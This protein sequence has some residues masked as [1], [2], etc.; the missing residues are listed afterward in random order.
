MDGTAGA[1]LGIFSRWLHI[2][3]VVTLVGGFV[4]ARYGVAPALETLPAAE[5]LPFSNK[6]VA[7]VRNLLYAAIAGALVSGLYNYL[8]K[9]SYPPHYHMLIGIKLLFVLH[10]FATAVLYT[11]PNANEGNRLRRLNWLV[12]SGVII[13]TISDVL[14]WLSISALTK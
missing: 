11:I 10:V 4:Y 9:T 6:I 2:T 8:S 1:V 7:N 5:R 12:I 13:I 14:R 3:S